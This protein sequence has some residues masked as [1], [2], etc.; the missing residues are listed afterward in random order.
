MTIE[1]RKVTLHNF[2]NLGFLLHKFN[3]E[4]LK[5]IRNEVNKILNN[6]DKAIP[7]NKNLAGNIEREFVLSE[8]VKHIND[9]IIPQIINYDQ[10]FN[11]INHFSYINKNVNI[12]LETS[13]VNFQKKYEFNPPHNHNGVFSFVIWLNIPYDIKDEMKNLSSINSKA[14]N[15]GCFNF[16]YCN[17]LGYIENYT[18]P[19]DKNYNNFMCL[20]PSK[21]IHYVN[22]FFISDEYRISVSGNFYFDVIGDLN[23]TK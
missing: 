18:M 4:E 11:F 17:T 1:D 15:P 19:I 8:S 10:H 3:D 12:K 9:L 13:W 7:F 16:S 22:P 5:P 6:F 20:F 21:M 23:D 2:T 14:N